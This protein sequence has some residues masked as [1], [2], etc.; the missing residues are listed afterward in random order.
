MIAIQKLQGGS[1][2]SART[3]FCPCF[4]GESFEKSLLKWIGAETPS[5][6]AGF[7]VLAWSN[8]SKR[9]DIWMRSLAQV[10]C[11]C[12]KWLS[13]P[14]A[15]LPGT[16]TTGTVRWSLELHYCQWGKVQTH[17]TETISIQV[18]AFILTVRT[19]ELVFK[20]PW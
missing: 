8:V 1:R 12:P 4:V 7:G 17:D 11:Q 10:P 19:R 13:A 3:D 14:S 20:W 18:S 15:S 9:Q 6:E 16:Q 2:K 5:W